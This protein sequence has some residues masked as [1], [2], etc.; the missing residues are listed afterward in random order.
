MPDAPNLLDSDFE[1]APD[2]DAHRGDYDLFCPDLEPGDALLFDAQVVHGSSA[3]YSTDRQRR[4]F[5]SR[6]CGNGVAYEARHATMP[7]LWEHGLANGDPLAGSLFPQILPQP[8]PAEGARR[9]GRPRAAAS[10]LRRAGNERHRRTGGGDEV[11]CPC[12]ARSVWME[13]QFWFEFGST[14]SYPA[15]MRIEALAA[16]RRVPVVLARIPARTDLSRP[17]LG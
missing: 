12:G 16:Q 14:Y 3:N 11:A 9:A 15:A 13:L 7:L 1:D 5:A 6:W 17:R 2:I 10:G 4:A 8:I